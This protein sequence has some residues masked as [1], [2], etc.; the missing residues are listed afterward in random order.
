MGQMDPRQ[1][2]VAACTSTGQAGQTS[3]Q[4]T[5]KSILAAD[6]IPPR[7]YNFRWN[8]AGLLNRRFNLSK[9]DYD[10]PLH[11][12]TS[13]TGEH[14]K[15]SALQIFPE[16]ML[17]G[18]EVLFHLVFQPKVAP[19]ETYLFA[20]RDPDDTLRLSL[21]FVKVVEFQDSVWIGD[22]FFP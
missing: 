2:R 15:I 8:I 19:N 1:P 3:R 6:P 20:I 17:P 22:T 5:T 16:A 21:S 7:S 10:F 4:T 12:K 18:P 9:P 11:I 13:S 14:F